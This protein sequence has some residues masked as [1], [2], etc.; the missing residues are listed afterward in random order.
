MERLP[1]EARNLVNRDVLQ[2]LERQA[3]PGRPQYAMYDIDEYELH[4]HPDLI[5]RL[6]VAAAGLDAPMVA[7]YGVPVLLHRDGVIF[8]VA[9]GM[10]ALI[11]RLPAD[12]QSHIIP[13]R[14]TYDIGAEWVSADAWLSNLSSREGTT[15]IRGWCRGA[16][17][18]AERLGHTGES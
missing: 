1:D 12:L 4:T 3:K 13:A 10:S 8:A 7:A 11:F 18:Y 6:E 15:R 5:E 9:Y 14:W 17:E 2:F 16:Y